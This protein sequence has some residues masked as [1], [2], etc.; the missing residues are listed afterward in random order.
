MRDFSA[1]GALS[2]AIETAADN[3]SRKLYPG[4]VVR[5]LLLALTLAS[6]VTAQYEVPRKA[7]EYPAHGSW[8]KFDIGAEYLIHSIPTDNGSLFARDYLVVKIAIY[9][10]SEPIVIS[11]AHFTLRINGKK[12]VL[13]AES[14]GFAAASIRYPDWEQRP[15][16]IGTV[17]NE[18]NDVI[19]GAP[20]RVPRFPGDPTV[21]QPIGLP[22]KDPNPG[23]VEGNPKPEASLDVLIGRAVLEEGKAST[24]RKGV[25]FFA[26]KGKLKSIRK[27]EL[28]YEDNRHDVKGERTP[29]TLTLM[30]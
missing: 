3:T 4:C 20:Q 10:K 16:M 6:I 28:V 24:P 21:G 27:L 5:G 15:V 7:V 17:G 26:F 11:H 9:P 2:A 23:D 1:G 25:L 18:N 12:S 22:R 29:L 8:P 19:I 14:P 30:Q 13:Y